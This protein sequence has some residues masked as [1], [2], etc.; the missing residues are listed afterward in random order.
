M[1]GFVNCL[2]EVNYGSNFCIRHH[3]TLTDSSTAWVVISLVNTK[4]PFSIMGMVEGLF[5]GVVG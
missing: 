3:L 5:T 1:H 2:P 4:V